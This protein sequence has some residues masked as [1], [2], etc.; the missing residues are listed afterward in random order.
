MV[1]LQRGTSRLRYFD[2][3]RARDH[4]DVITIYL[5]SYKFVPRDSQ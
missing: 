3:F 4:Y 5:T 1:E 2:F